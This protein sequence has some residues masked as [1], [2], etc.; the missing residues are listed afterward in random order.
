MTDFLTELPLFCLF[1]TVAAYQFGLWCRKKT[2]ATLCNPLLIS[3][4]LVTGVLLLT[5]ISPEKSPDFPGC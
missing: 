3:I 5:G 4:I 2:G 1:L